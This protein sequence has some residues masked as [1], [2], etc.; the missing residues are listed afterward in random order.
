MKNITYSPHIALN[1]M[2]KIF[3]HSVDICEINL[4]PDPLKCCP[5]ML[6]VRHRNPTLMQGCLAACGKL[7]C[8]EITL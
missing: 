5:A 7:E 2:G 3:T 1:C 8:K 6:R 4:K